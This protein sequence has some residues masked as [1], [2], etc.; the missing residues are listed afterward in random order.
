MIIKELPIRL[1]YAFTCATI[2]IDLG[3]AQAH[4]RRL[5]N[6]YAFISFYHSFPPIFSFSP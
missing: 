6:T 2:G 4:A 3:A 1:V 5:R